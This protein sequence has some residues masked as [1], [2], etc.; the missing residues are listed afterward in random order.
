MT[1][2]SSRLASSIRDFA[3]KIG[4]VKQEERRPAKAAGRLAG[5]F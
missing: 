2:N 4:A 1:E 3:R 5:L